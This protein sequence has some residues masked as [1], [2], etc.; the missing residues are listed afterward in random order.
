MRCWRRYKNWISNHTNIFVVWIVLFFFTRNWMKLFR[1]ILFSVHLCWA[2]NTDDIVSGSCIHPYRFVSLLQISACFFLRSF[3][4]K[5]ADNPCVTCLCLNFLLP[6]FT[7]SHKRTICSTYCMSFF[8][9]L[10]LLF[11]R[12][13]F[14]CTVL[15]VFVDTH[16]KF[17]T[18]KYNT[19]CFCRSLSLVMI[20][21]LTV[22]RCTNENWHKT[23]KCTSI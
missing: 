10:S 8:L 13:F 19:I 20:V 4:N 3:D 21:S 14:F 1:V 6:L 15:A 23:K 5:L 22:A 9:S 16:W 7:Q 11:H 17:R 12:F 2:F 18:L